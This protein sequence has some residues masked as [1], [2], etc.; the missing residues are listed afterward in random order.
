M[1]VLFIRKSHFATFIGH[2]HPSQR[3]LDWI[4]PTVKH[5]SGF[6]CHNMW[7]SPNDNYAVYFN[8]PIR[9]PGKWNCRKISFNIVHLV[10]WF[11]GIFPK[12]LMAELNTMV[13][14]ILAKRICRIS[15]THTVAFSRLDSLQSHYICIQFARNNRPIQEKLNYTCPCR[16]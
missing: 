2:I 5:F 10:R 9:I 3:N 12:L 16:R 15:T 1:A 11:L 7:C 4:D 14:W 8:S 13:N 6:S